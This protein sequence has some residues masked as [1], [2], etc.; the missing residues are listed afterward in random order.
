MSSDATKPKTMLRNAVIGTAVAGAE[1]L[2]IGHV[3]DRIRVHQVTHVEE[4]SVLKAA[5]HI[6]ELGG[7][8]EFYVGLRWNLVI[9][10]GKHAFRW[11]L[12]PTVDKIIRDSV[13]PKNS[14][15]W[16]VVSTSAAVFAFL[17]TTL[18]K[19]PAESLKTKE[20]TR[21]N[22][23][24]VLDRIRS[25]G[26]RKTL[27]SGW[28]AIMIR[29]TVSWVSFRL[30]VDFSQNYITKLFFPSGTG[31]GSKNSASSSSSNSTP[32]KSLKA[33]LL[34]SVFS[35]VINAAIVCPFDAVTI[36]IQKDSGLPSSAVRHYFQS[37]SFLYRTYGMKVF[38]SAWRIKFARSI[39]YA[40]IFQVLW[41]YLDSDAVA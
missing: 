2:T 7:L 34:T 22:N 17:E 15:S 13:L 16:Q 1:L 35:G 30:S 41:D 29:Q 37:F 24:S 31:V 28:S 18:I 20:M 11:G 32:D 19:C 6:Y 27:W 5:R 12:M 36:H 38:Y 40:A 10:C 14:P 39:A 9:Y 8:K 25:E 3:M 21:L 23:R 26:V 4:K 33:K